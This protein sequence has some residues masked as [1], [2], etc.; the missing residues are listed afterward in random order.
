MRKLNGVDWYFYYYPNDN[1]I[2]LLDVYD[3]IEV[4][5]GFLVSLTKDN[6]KLYA[7][8]RDFKSFV[9]Y[10]YKVTDPSKRSFFEIILGDKKQRPKFD[11]DIE[12]DNIEE[13]G[14]KTLA[15][16]ISSFR[17][18]IPDIDL[19]K[20]VMIFTSHSNTKRSF[21]VVIK[22]YYHNNNNE[23]K[24]FYNMVLEKIDVQYRC[25]I[26]PAVY[27]SLQQFRIFGSQKEDSNRPKIQLL[28]FRGLKFKTVG[29]I[30]DTLITNIKNCKHLKCVKP[31]LQTSMT[32][33]QDL[34][35][36]LAEKALEIINIPSLTIDSIEGNLV[37]LKN[38]SGYY[39]KPCD[40]IHEKQN[41][42]LVIF[43][44]IIYMNCRRFDTEGLGVK[45]GR[46]DGKTMEDYN[47]NT[48]VPHLETGDSSDDEEE[49]ESDIA[50]LEGVEEE[51]IKCPKIVKT[52]N[53][54][55]K[56]K[57]FKV[58]KVD[59]NLEDKAIQYLMSMV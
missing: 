48:F 15:R 5:Q 44:P 6:F 11:L 24:A 39:C 54:I 22:N 1:G 58:D 32:Y 47:N 35:M 31:T 33:V 37:S 42:Y 36:S 16:L 29:G 45:V 18:F 3:E 7:L 8:F 12:G 13:L 53:N 55:E 10:N 28:E 40:R 38:N 50:T 43:P 9:K 17:F 14:N 56:L 20:D 49:K 26:D 52:N 25:Y 27:S 46:L 41:P 59:D 34:D 19:E 23:A 57:Y 51:V 30:E 21:H 4:Q 2:A